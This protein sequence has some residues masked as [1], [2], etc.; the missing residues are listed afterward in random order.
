MTG[1]LSPA[2]E[3][4][5]S[6]TS[7][8]ERAAEAGAARVRRERAALVRPDGSPMF[9][10]QEQAERERAM[11][12]GAGVAYDAATSRYGALADAERATAEAALTTLD[13]EDG[14]SRLTEAERAAA[15]TRQPFIAED[16]ATLT[17]PELARRARAAIAAKDKASGYLWLRGLERRPR[18]TP[19]D[20][21]ELGTVLAEL[22]ALLGL[23]GQAERRRTIERKIEATKSLKGRVDT[24]RRRVDGRHERMEAGL[25]RQL[26][27][28]F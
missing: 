10:P 13:G 1:Y 11:L 12:E 21:A 4:F 20:G 3:L 25:R 28:M 2:D 27:G 23:D 7:A 24:A 6:E 8:I 16:A 19:A 15:S 18:T 22:R 5:P 14:W 26:Q 17:A 9:T